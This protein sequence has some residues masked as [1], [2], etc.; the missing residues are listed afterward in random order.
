MIYILLKFTS[1]PNGMQARCYS[2]TGSR[3]NSSRGT[4]IVETRGELK[5]MPLKD[6]VTRPKQILVFEQMLDR[7]VIKK[8]LFHG[9]LPHTTKH[10]RNMGDVPN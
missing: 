1:E 4:G 3:P 6:P 7:K 2:D 9:A 5:T 8:M 10:V